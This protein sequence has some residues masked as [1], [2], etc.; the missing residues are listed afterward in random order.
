MVQKIYNLFVK[1]SITILLVLTLW[2]VVNG[3]LKESKGNFEFGNLMDFFNTLG[4][5]GTLLVAFKAYKAAPNWI[6][7]KNTEIAHT[8]ATEFFSENIIQL[9]SEIEDLRNLHSTFVKFSDTINYIKYWDHDLQ[10]ELDENMV[11]AKTIISNIKSRN[12]EFEIYFNAY[13]WSFKN[14][15]KKEISIIQNNPHS[16]GVKMQNYLDLY[17]E[18]YDSGNP[19]S[20]NNEIFNN[21]LNS[22]KDYNSQI[23]KLLDEMVAT[24]QLI[25]KS[26]RSPEEYFDM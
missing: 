13:K 14:I 17:Q 23:T 11:R 15:F 20:A 21:R 19:M 9:Q 5:L 24:L 4:T 18:V 2:L 22:L 10:Y 6:K 12:N 26:K 8:K 7:S 25:I 3:A 16:V 1:I